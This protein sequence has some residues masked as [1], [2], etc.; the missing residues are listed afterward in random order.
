MMVVE[1]KRPDL[2]DALGIDQIHRHQ[3]IR[4]H[5]LGVADGEWR[6]LYESARRPPD[7]DDREAFGEEFVRLIGKQVAD[8][9]RPES[10]V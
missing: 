8:A 10:S 1:S 7:V 9:L 6:F 5:R 2:T 4:T 3:I